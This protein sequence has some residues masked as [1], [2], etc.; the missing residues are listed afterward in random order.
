[1]WFVDDKLSIHFGENKTELILFSKTKR[2]SKVNINYRN[3]N[4]KQ[5]HTAE[6]LRCH[7]DS[8]LSSESM[9]KKVFQELILSKV[10]TSIYHRNLKD[11]DA[12]F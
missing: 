7:L 4:I 1:M 11:S 3:H 9:A 10:K 8:N 6:Y 12:I 2:P 5:Y